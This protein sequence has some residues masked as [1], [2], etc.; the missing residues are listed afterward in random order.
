[1]AFEIPGSLP[2]NLVKQ[3]DKTFWLLYRVN[4]NSPSRNLEKG[5]LCTHIPTS[6]IP[7]RGGVKQK[8]DNFCEVRHCPQLFRVS[9]TTSSPHRAPL[10]RESI[11]LL[12]S[13]R[14]SKGSL[15]KLQWSSI[16]PYAPIGGQNH[17]YGWTYS[18]K[19]G[20]CICGSAWLQSLVQITQQGGARQDLSVEPIGSIATVLGMTWF[21]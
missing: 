10:V 17:R 7:T 9:P 12:F 13:R 11:S 4:A 15:S 3:S 20:D 5:G 1:M 8:V 21:V 19:A 16:I 2:R 18:R 14:I 6:E